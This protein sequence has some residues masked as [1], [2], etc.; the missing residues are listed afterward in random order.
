MSSLFM[1]M[2]NPDNAKK[3]GEKLRVYG[4]SPDGIFQRGAEVL[5]AAGNDSSGVIICTARFRDMNYLSLLE[6]LSAGYRL[7]V[8]SSDPEVD[9]SSGRVE[10]LLNP[11]KTMDLV[12]K[13]AQMTG[14]LGKPREKKSF[15][16]KRSPEE[17]QLINEAKRLLMERDHI[18]EPEAFR[19]I[20]KSSM[21]SGRNMVESARMVILL[22]S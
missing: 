13:L 19:F 18:T 20:Q 16:K 12:N 14:G 17:E 3:I 22:N 9:T 6:Y 4:Y 2:P 7:L 15:V 1:L 5:E 11:F 10:V 21:D 8:L